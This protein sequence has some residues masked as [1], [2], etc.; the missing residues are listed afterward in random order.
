MSRPVLEFF[1]FEGCPFC[2]KVV[3]VIKDEKLKVT[4]KDIFHNPDFRDQLIQDTG[5]KMVPCLYI[6]GNPMHESDDIINWI[7]ENSSNLEKEI[8]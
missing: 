2:Q 4:F 6:D 5:K 7:K 8:L 1:F 3:S